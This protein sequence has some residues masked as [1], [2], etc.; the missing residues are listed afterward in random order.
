MD[1]S[2]SGAARAVTKEALDEAVA[3]KFGLRRED[4]P[5]EL[6]TEEYAQTA[7]KYCGMSFLVA[8]EMRELQDRLVSAEATVE[9]WRDRIARTTRAEAERD[10]AVRLSEELRAKAQAMARQRRRIRQAGDSVSRS[11]RDARKSHSRLQTAVHDAFG[12]PTDPEELSG[13]GNKWLGG[14]CDEWMDRAR[15]FAEMARARQLEGSIAASRKQSQ[16][17]AA[18]RAAAEEAAEA[19]GEELQVVRSKLRRVESRAEQAEAQAA[20]A[21]EAEAASRKRLAESER[22]AGAAGSERIAELESM[23][24][25]AA[26]THTQELEAS[27][28]VAQQQLEALKTDME[29]A[30]ARVMEEHAATLTSERAASEEAQAQQDPL[31]EQLVCL[32]AEVEAHSGRA[33]RAEADLRQCREDLELT[34]RR[35]SELSKLEQTARQEAAEARDSASLIE[36]QGKRSIEELQAALATAADDA[37]SSSAQ[38]AE[39]I[40][41]SLQAAHERAV[42]VLKDEHQLVVASLQAE[43]E[44]QSKKQEA[45]YESRLAALVVK[46]GESS[47][48]AAVAE[49]SMRSSQARGLEEHVDV[50]AALQDRVSA[51][52]TQASEALSRL[53]ASQSEAAEALSR[54]KASQSEVSGLQDR[55]AKAEAEL[56]ARAGAASVAEAAAARSAEEWRAALASAGS[57]LLFLEASERRSAPAASAGRPIEQAAVGSLLSRVGAG[58][59][60]AGLG[61]VCSRA[62]QLAQELREEV[63]SMRLTIER[64]CAERMFL[65]EELNGFREGA[66]MERLTVEQVRRG[67]TTAHAGPGG[68]GARSGSARSTSRVDGVPGSVGLRRHGSSGLASAGQMALGGGAGGARG[69]GVAGSGGSWTSA[70]GRAGGRRGHRR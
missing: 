4:L 70:R 5:E 6:Q 16:A 44:A 12:A 21:R 46:V 26:T 30:R 69:A 64:E 7:C 15:G 34:T 33:A 38:H 29:A 51:A 43:H 3:D 66:G 11:L 37:K 65:M 53:K 56:A 25:R 62:R 59:D 55:L 54:L 32:Q 9:G 58:A 57:L 67:G 36:V 2:A 20:A 10:D 24:R 19:A 61:M 47:K 45:G 31:K 22:D 8:T 28:S 23:L 18:V 14:F 40:K 68:S 41:T 1:G 63:D 42:T 27:R 48:R 52:E 39:E 50:V 35:A 49:A 17:V 60:S 13:T